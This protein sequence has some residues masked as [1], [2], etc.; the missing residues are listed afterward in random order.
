MSNILPQS[1]VGRIEFMESHVA[2]WAASASAIGTTPAAVAAATARTTAARAAFQAHQLAQEQAR[3]AT[4]T[5]YDAV[6]A[7]SDSA[8]DIIKQVRARAA[9]DG[10]A[11]Y[12]LALLPV[13]A[14]PS[15][16][17][18]PGTPT[19]FNAALNPD[20]SLRLSWKCANPRGTQGTIYQIARSAGG[21]PLIIL[22]TSGKR[23]YTDSTVPAGAASVEYQI[24]ALRSTRVGTP[25]RFGVKL[26][27]A[28]GAAVA[29][30]QTRL[31]A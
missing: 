15:P 24:T 1:R 28:G 13:P 29:S 11:V 26:G 14:A 5:F 10:S 16:S 6:A 31:A 23:S 4:Q 18:A 19:A 25:A 3:A 27:V 17:P 8:S 30:F 21:G 20:G 2:A 12:T 22:G 7:M 9:T